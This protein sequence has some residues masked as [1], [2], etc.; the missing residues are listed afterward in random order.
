[1]PVGSPLANAQVGQVLGFNVKM[2]SEA[3]NVAYLYHP[4]FMEMAVQK[5]LNV[6]MYDQGVEGKRS[7]RVNS[8]LLFGKVQVS[9]LRVVTLT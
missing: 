2:T 8:T 9:N 6:K 1:M 3:G 7:M 4:Q 5:E